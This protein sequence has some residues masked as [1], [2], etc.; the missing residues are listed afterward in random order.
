MLSIF[1]DNGTVQR[2]RINFCRSVVALNIDLGLKS[3]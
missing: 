3:F 1:A 2:I